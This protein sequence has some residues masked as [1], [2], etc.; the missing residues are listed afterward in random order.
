MTHIVTYICCFAHRIVICLAQG[1][2]RAQRRFFDCFAPMNACRY[3]MLFVSHS[4]HRGRGDSHYFKLSISRFRLYMARYTEIPRYGCRGNRHGMTLECEDTEHRPPPSLHGANGAVQSP[5]GRTDTK[6]DCLT[7]SHGGT[8]TRRRTAFSIFHFPFSVSRDTHPH[9]NCISNST[10]LRC[11][12][13][14]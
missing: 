7:R 14:K 1:T 4:A 8:E 11:P 12:P 13:R 6:D 3:E 5:S 2:Q 10:S 9:T